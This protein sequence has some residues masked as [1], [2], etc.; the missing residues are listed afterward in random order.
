MP[1][2]LNRREESRRNDVI[3][4]K[5]STA[6]MEH[7]S[8]IDFKACITKPITTFHLSTKRWLLFLWYRVPNGLGNR[9]NTSCKSWG[10][11]HRFHSFCGF[12]HKH[13]RI[14]NLITMSP[15]SSARGGWWLITWVGTWAGTKGKTKNVAT[16]IFESP[17]CLEMVDIDVREAHWENKV[18]LLRRIRKQQSLM[19]VKNY[20][21]SNAEL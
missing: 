15:A 11:R 12:L 16:W 5:E 3:S 9:D 18:V 7:T 2:R 21:E 10:D 1:R 4:R 17:A 14:L 13:T 8:E 19:Y 6:P 20:W